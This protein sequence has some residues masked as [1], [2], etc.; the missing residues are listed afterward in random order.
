MEELGE[1]EKSSAKGIEDD[2]KSFE[3]DGNFVGVDLDETAEILGTGGAEGVPDDIAEEKPQDD[4]F[5]GWDGLLA[6][7]CGH[8]AR[9]SKGV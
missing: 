7:S 6:E 3:G 9:E 5:E 4:C 2:G 8:G 1:A